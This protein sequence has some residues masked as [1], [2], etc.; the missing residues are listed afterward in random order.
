MGAFVCQIFLRKKKKERTCM[1]WLFLSPLGQYQLPPVSPVYTSTALSHRACNQT[2]P[3]Y[4][5]IYNEPSHEIMV[6]FVLRKLILQMRMRSHPVGPDVW[7]LVGPFVY[8][9]TSC[10]WTAKALVKAHL[11]AYVISTTISWA[12]SIISIRLH[13]VLN[14]RPL[15]VSTSFM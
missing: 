1:R 5:T 7:F 13:V 14:A 11:V 12:D 8:C 6:L 2:I 4:L 9:H 15:E 10:V 3:A